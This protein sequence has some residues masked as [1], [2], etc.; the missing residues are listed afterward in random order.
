M[1]KSTALR[2]VKDELK[3]ATDHHGSFNS[4]HEGYAVLAEELDELWDEVKANRGATHRGVSE[5]V[6]VAAMALRF[7]VDLC[8]EPVA[9]EHERKVT[10]FYSHDMEGRS[11]GGCYSG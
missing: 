5:A 8:E 10:R 2:L 11:G 9:A 7:L 3:R 6:Q 4:C 1:K